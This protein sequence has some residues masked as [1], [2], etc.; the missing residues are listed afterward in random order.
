MAFALHQHPGLKPPSGTTKHNQTIK[1]K[2]DIFI[3]ALLYGALER[4]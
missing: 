1:T 4:I 2:A 3:S